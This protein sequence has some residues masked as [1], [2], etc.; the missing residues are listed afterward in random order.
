MNI[1]EESRGEIK[2]D[3]RT[4]LREKKKKKKTV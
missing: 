1:E 3:K 4:I 2:K